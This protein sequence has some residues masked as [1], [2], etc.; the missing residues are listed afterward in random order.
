MDNL[1][2]STARPQIGAVKPERVEI[3][4]DT[5]S[6]PF[7][8]TTGIRHVPL[9]ERGKGRMRECE[10]HLSTIYL[11]RNLPRSVGP[12]Y[13]QVRHHVRSLL[14]MIDGDF[15]VPFLVNG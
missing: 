15:E 11:Y 12:S 14:Y 5:V 2:L 4:A 1:G 7:L 13:S 9:G 6:T 10:I 3:V 8:A